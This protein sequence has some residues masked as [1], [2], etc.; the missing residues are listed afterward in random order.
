MSIRKKASRNLRDALFFLFIHYKSLIG[1]AKNKTKA[2]LIRP[3]EQTAN[4]PTDP[5][6][7][8]ARPPKNIATGIRP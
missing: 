7:V 8:I 1:L 2:V 5:R 4:K 3:P 6:Y